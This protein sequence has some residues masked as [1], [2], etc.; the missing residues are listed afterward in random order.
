MRL[1]SQ[2]LKAGDVTERWIGKGL[3]PPAQYQS[4]RLTQGGGLKN[5]HAQAYD[6]KRNGGDN[7]G[8]IVHREQGLSEKAWMPCVFGCMSGAILTI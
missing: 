4:G 5:R 7:K 1:G 3:S 8:L 6:V 2:P